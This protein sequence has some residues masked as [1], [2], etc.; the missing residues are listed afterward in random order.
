MCDF[1]LTL[2]RT[3]I[4]NQVHSSDSEKLYRKQKNELY[5]FD[6]ECVPF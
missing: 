6:F 2:E 5:Y 3:M 4:W 1:E